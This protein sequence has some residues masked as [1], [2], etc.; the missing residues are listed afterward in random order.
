MSSV[1]QITRN[2][3][4]G[5]SRW[6]QGYD[7]YLLLLSESIPTHSYLR[8]LLTGIVKV[9]GKGEYPARRVNR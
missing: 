5:G 7:S 2:T 4:S 1:R 9:F 6:L 3:S 8:G